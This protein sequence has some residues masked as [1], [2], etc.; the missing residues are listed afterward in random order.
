MEGQTPS[1]PGLPQDSQ[2]VAPSVR[3]ARVVVDGPVMR[4]LLL[5]I[6]PWYRSFF[7]ELRDLIHPEKLPPL[8][9]TSRPVAVK[10]MW[11]K[12]PYRKY[13]A[14]LSLLAHV[15]V[16]GLLIIPLTLG[17]IDVMPK[18]LVFSPAD[19]SEIE[20]SL[21]PSITKAGGG[22]GGGD[23][24]PTPASIGELPKASLTQLSPP[25]VIIKNPDPEIPVTP[26][27]VVPPDILL[28]QVNMAQLGDPL[29]GLNMPSN[30]PGFGG[31]IG[32]GSGGGVGSGRGRGVGPGEGGGFGGGTFR[33][34]GGVS[35]PQLVFKVDPEYSEQ[36]R[37]SKFQGVVLLS[38]V[39]QKDGTVRDIRVVRALG[40]GLDEKAVEAVRQW[41][42]RPG[43]KAGVPVDVSAQVEVIFR[44]L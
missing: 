2:A 19:L 33:V 37:K 39:V 28:P 22:G 21:P 5:E 3:A 14:P 20:L 1:Q 15:V 18:G 24:S 16:I 34:G 27:V 32:D 36:A 12:N 10:D 42:F 9:L 41:R 40:L 13:T 8:L 25:T 44:L 35:A 31:G 7:R 4:G 23:R 26:T 38:L 6:D 43:E 29:A 17:V 11:S 30:G